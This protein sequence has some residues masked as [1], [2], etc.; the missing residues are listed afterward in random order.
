VSKSPTEPRA[1]APLTRTPALE[2]LLQR[3]RGRLLRLIWMHGTGTVLTVAAAWLVFAFLADW[4]LHV[5]RAI[6]L[7]HFA[8]LLVLPPYFLWRDLVRP[9]RRVPDRAGLAVL[10]ERSDPELKELLVSATEFQQ[11]HVAP[12]GGGDDALRTE[13]VGRVLDAAE[14]RARGLTL[15]GV[16]DA[17]PPS[18]RFASGLSCATVALALLLA[19]GEH[20]RIFFARMVGGSTPWPKR[21]ELAVNVPILGERARIERDEDEIRVYVARG[22]DVPV[23]VEARGVV[24]D[25]VTLHF[26]GAADATLP[27]GSGNTFRT[28]LRSRE[29]DFS[30]HATGGD[31]R[32]ARPRVR[33]HVLQPPDVTD[34]AVAIEP[35][36]YTGLADRLE[37][38]RDVEVLRGS[39]LVV[40]VATE[41]AD[42]EGV[43]RLLPEDRVVPL[44]P[45]PFPAADGGGAEADA[46]PPAEARG[47][48]AGLAFELE[49]ERSL[50]YRFELRDDT[51]LANPDPGLF[52]IEVLEDRPPE[53]QLLAP[54]RSDV[55]TV[56]GGA[57][58]LRA[59]V[60]DDFGLAEVRWRVT[61]AAQ[62][63]G[64][65]AVDA[66][67]GELELRRLVDVEPGQVVPEHVGHVSRRLEVAELAAP[68]APPAEGQ[69]F[70]IEVLASDNELPEANE[71]R[72]N[73]VRLRIVSSDE[74]LRRVQDRLARARLQANS[75]AEL[76]RS[77]RVRVEDLLDAL[78]TD[79]LLGT[80]DDLALQ[81][82]LTG[83]R[84]VEGDARALSR[85]LASIT[86]SVLYARVDDKAG[87]LFASLDAA[88][89]TATDRGFQADVWLELC[90]SYRSGA[91]GSA[92]LAGNLIDLLGL[93]L[94]ISDGV[95]GR[96]PERDRRRR[97]P[98]RAPGGP[99]G[100]DR[101]AGAH[102]GPARAAG[103]VG[104][105]PVRAHADARHPQPPVRARATHDAVRLGEVT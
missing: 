8:V 80:G 40:H 9:L 24:P 36:A 83:Q 4:G 66:R 18:L 62:P 37:R 58:A 60:R 105:L 55:E 89:A 73:T 61:D 63:D 90:A 47:E 45:R 68:G 22:S 46:A 19:G 64:G 92:G 21:T 12:G 11:Q 75:L 42:A 65:E 15:Q 88:M 44:L 95:A 96:R 77:K 74:L 25:E 94:E 33:V 34:L 57:L 41:P 30:F 2:S 49:A 14:E 97:G 71:G 103:G 78:Q 48:R 23:L 6:R 54:G 5:P 87:A 91:L 52:G 51:G 69:Q 67:G 35:P 43:A 50:R 86:E 53:V 101:D 100:A 10:A 31:D 56:V 13:L 1:D 32:D 102:R 84:R 20:A 85:E 17:K 81:A 28:V 3:L 38:N 59:R 29:Q 99:G 93:A 79:G 7:F 104:Q 16:L 26:E 72:S 39:K 82:A 98:G 76:Q 70:S 27:R